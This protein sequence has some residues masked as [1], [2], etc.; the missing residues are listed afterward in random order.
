MLFLFFSGFDVLTDG[1]DEDSVALFC[2]YISTISPT[3]FLMSLKSFV[4]IVVISFT[5]G[6]FGFKIVHDLTS[7]CVRNVPLLT[8]ID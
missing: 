2:L 1:S 7:I 3:L 5:S 4:A 8:S 6:I